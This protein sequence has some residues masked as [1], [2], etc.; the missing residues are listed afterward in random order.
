MSSYEFFVTYQMPHAGLDE[1]M[2]TPEVERKAA[3]VTMQT[4][5]STWMAAHANVVTETA[6]VGKPKRVTATGIE[7]ARIEDAR[8]DVFVCGSTITRSGSGDVQRSSTLWYSWQLD[9]SNAY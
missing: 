8:N 4:A 2:K 6:G 5:W 9:R 1:W 3:E 7:D